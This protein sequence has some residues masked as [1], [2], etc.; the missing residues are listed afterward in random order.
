MF[1]IYKIYIIYI[2]KY[3]YIKHKGKLRQISPFAK[4]KKI[5]GAFFAFF[6]SA[7]RFTFEATLS[8]HTA[9]PL[10]PIRLRHTVTSVTRL[11]PGLRTAFSFRS[12]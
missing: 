12:P 2:Y 5:T 10:V 8:Q 1:Y 6:F 4:G 9:S 7:T 3:I 11:N